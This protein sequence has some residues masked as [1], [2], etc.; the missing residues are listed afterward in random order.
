MCGQVAGAAGAAA[1]SNVP[2]CSRRTPTPAAQALVEGEL[3][4]RR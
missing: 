2:S 3:K 4:A 1:P